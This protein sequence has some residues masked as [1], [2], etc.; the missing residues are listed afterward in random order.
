MYIQSVFTGSYLRSGRN[1][2]RTGSEPDP[3]TLDPAGFTKFTG[4][5]AGSGAGS[6]APLTQCDRCE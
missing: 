1:R 6:G 4:Y 2:I 3:D 5:P